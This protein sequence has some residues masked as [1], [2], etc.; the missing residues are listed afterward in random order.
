MT[1]EAPGPCGHCKPCMPCGFGYMAKESLPW[2]TIIQRSSRMCFST[3][4]DIEDLSAIRESYG[5]VNEQLLEVCRKM[6]QEFDPKDLERAAYLVTELRTLKACEEKL[7]ELEQ[8]EDA[9]SVI[10]GEK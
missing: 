4:S 6:Q 9:V 1:R 2:L 3:G 5:E 8:F 10:Q 7:E